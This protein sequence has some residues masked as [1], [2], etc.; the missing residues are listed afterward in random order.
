MGYDCIHDYPWLCEDCPCLIEY[1]T[2]DNNALVPD[3][4]TNLF[5]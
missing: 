4:A 1:M 3:D 5:K 2:K